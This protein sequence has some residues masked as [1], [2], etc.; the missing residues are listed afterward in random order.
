MSSNPTQKNQ[1]NAC[2]VSIHRIAH[3]DLCPSAV[4]ECIPSRTHSQVN[5]SIPPIL[6][7][8]RV[9]Q[10]LRRKE[11][12]T[13]WNFATYR[14]SRGSQCWGYCGHARCSQVKSKCSL[15]KSGSR[16][17]CVVTPSKSTLKSS[18]VMYSWPR[19]AKPKVE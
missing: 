12:I 17:K 13:V 4:F 18:G 11:H 16:V 15:I 7:H 3:G 14:N 8:W 9:L 10:S 5:A 1:S 2:Q 6:R 19:R